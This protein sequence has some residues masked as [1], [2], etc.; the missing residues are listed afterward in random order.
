MNGFIGIMSAILISAFM[1][2]AMLS[3]S[4]NAFA[5]RFNQLRHIDE[6]R[7][8]VGAYSC[9]FAALEKFEEDSSYDPHESML[10]LPFGN[11]SDGCLVH[12]LSVG[13]SSLSLSLEY[14]SG[15][16]TSSVAATAHLNPD[17]TLSPGP[18]IFGTST[19]P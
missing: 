4:A 10:G 7:S 11:P 15:M 1:T 6:V 12:S 19:P 14:R 2:A 18:F 17:G 9:A 13:T 3:A 8:S 16:A 5:T